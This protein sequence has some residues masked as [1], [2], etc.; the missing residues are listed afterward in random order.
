MDEENIRFEGEIKI[1]PVFVGDIWELDDKIRRAVSLV[2]ECDGDVKELLDPLINH[3]CDAVC[4]MCHY[5]GFEKPDDV[6][7]NPYHYY[8][9]KLDGKE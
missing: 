2:N 5:L 4:D 6:F 9:I 3:T 1:A 7:C 8:F